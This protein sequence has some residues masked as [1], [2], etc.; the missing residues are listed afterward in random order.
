[1][2]RTRSGQA[3][4]TVVELCADREDPPRCS[5]QTLDRFYRECLNSFPKRSPRL[6]LKERSGSA[7]NAMS[8]LRRHSRGKATPSPLPPTLLRHAYMTAFTEDVADP[9][10]LRSFGVPYWAQAP[11]FGQGPIV[12]YSLE[13]LARN[14]IVGKTVRQAG[15]PR[16]LLP[17]DTTRGTPS[18]RSSSPPTGCRGL[19][20]GSLGWWLRCEVA[21]TSAYETFTSEA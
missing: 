13:K 4:D 7:Q 20:I 19:L 18:E 1:M 9:L 15:N 3:G 5:A 21:M 11:R 17:N 6:H 16:D 14:R 2:A 12:M 10:F 8:R